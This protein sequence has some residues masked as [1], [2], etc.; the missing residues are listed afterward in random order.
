MRS[1]AG[2]R[3]DLEF[4]I[5]QRT[6]ELEMANARLQKVLEVESVGVMFWDLSTGCMTDANDAFLKMMGYSR[7]EVEAGELTWQKLTPPEYIAVSL[8]EIRKFEV[9]GRIGPYEK[10]Y[11]RKDGTRQ[12]MIFA[13][14]SLG[15][16]ACI[17]FCVDISDRKHVE[18]A[19]RESEEQ[20][21]ILTENLQSAVAL[22]DEHG[23]FVIVN[24]SFRR[25]FQIPTDA[26]ILNINNRDWSQWKVFDEQG[27][28]LEVDE[29]PAR[30]AALTGRAVKNHL[31]RVEAPGSMQSKWLLVSAAPILGAGGS[32]QRLICTYYDITERRAAEEA[33]RQ[34]EARYRMLHES[35]RDAFVQVS[36]DGRI[37]EYNDLFCQMLGYS[38]EE[39]ATLTYLDL[40]PVKWH[41]VEAE[42][43][44]SQ[45]LPRGYSDVYEKEYRR[46]DGMVIPVEL[47]TILSRDEK[48]MPAA[49][50]AI[51]RDI[52]SRKLAEEAL[53]TINEKLEQRVAERTKEIEQ[54]ANHLRALASELTMAEQR[55]RRRLAQLLHDGLQQILVS[56]RMR[57]SKLTHDENQETRHRAA[58]V[59][60]LISEC[61]EMSRSLTAELSPPI[62]HEGG[63]V[64]ALEWLARWIFNKYGLEVELDAR[65]TVG[66]EAEDLN[67]LLFQAV[68]ELLFNIVKH[69]GVSHAR[70][71]VARSGDRI[72]IAVSDE[73]AGFNPA[74][75]RSTTS[76]SGGF[77]LFS[78][79]ERLKLLG[80]H[81]EIQSAP[82]QGSR[83]I[84]CASLPMAE[85]T[86]A[87]VES[88]SLKKVGVA[89][90]TADII[91][92]G[93][94]LHRIRVMLVDDHLV[95]RQGL[96]LLIREESDLEIVGEASNGEVA[97]E[98]A[99]SLRPD[100]ILMDI[101]MPR[102]NGIEAARRIHSEMPEVQII[103]LSMFDENERAQAMLVAGAVKYLTKSGPSE[104]L[105]NA[106]RTVAGKQ[107]RD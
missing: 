73:G 64:P 75:L 50:W 87:A 7:R 31:V 27:A 4:L 90:S 38:P 88:D 36:L 83:F 48:G 84:L 58:E 67:I 71:E 1:E 39:I 78:I 20:F 103:G 6:A 9:T 93:E 26:N 13:G 82:G 3:Q 29:H 76:D 11:L 18:E 105:I 24:S 30:K 85:S 68:R 69:A 89:F 23:A 57:L 43:L 100:V 96:G 79:G 99:R 19:L 59:S 65:A 66:P 15:G 17:E 47:R 14:S 5:Q 63:L 77:G 46:K 97:I 81:L 56:S 52:S 86:A 72:E 33:L 70:V 22:V 10:E 102:M 2:Q 101:N 106:I 104:D 62:L 61:I 40:T 41:A 25:I 35:L 95:M 49:M 8:A 91:S 16:N 107:V 54:Q 74:V 92:G 42:I 44:R 32:I 34:S 53:K 55:E 12:W 51:V 21:R 98:L 45:I 94:K 28:L 37:L 60:D 80:G